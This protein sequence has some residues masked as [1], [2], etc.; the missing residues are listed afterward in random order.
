MLR[1]ERNVLMGIVRASRRKN[2]SS[3]KIPRHEDDRSRLHSFNQEPC[4]GPFQTHSRGGG[5]G[6]WGS[7]VT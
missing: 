1:V 7:C 6:G 4:G 5:G 3:K 2:H